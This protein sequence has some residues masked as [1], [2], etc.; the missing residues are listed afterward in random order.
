MKYGDLKN[1]QKLRTPKGANIITSHVL[2]KVKQLDD[3]SKMVKARIAPHGDKDDMKD[4]LKKDSATC[5]PVGMRIL[6]SISV[7]KSWL[8][9][10]IDFKSD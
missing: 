4:D 9:C 2:Y 5:S 3:G 8:L 1:L 10:K 7:I 6:L